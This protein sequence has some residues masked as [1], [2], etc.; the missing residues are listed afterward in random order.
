[1]LLDKVVGYF[2]RLFIL[3][4]EPIV[5]ANFSFELLKDRLGLVAEPE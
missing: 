2:S 4:I 1:M 3:V 5:K